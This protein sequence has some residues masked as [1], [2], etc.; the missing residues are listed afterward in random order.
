MRKVF[1]VEVILKIFEFSLNLDQSQGCIS[2]R[3]KVTACQSQS[4]FWVEDKILNHWKNSLS[5]LSVIKRL[6]KIY[7]DFIRQSDLED[8]RIFFYSRPIQSPYLKQFQSYSSPKWDTDYLE[9]FFSH[10]IVK[11]ISDYFY[12]FFYYAK[13]THD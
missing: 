10:W 6:K 1:S 12:S 3:L 11:T 9:F 2:N 7:W 5:F 8:F 13:T 4:L